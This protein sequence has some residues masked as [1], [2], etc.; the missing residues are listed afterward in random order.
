M[1]IIIILFTF[2]PLMVFGSNKNCY[3][4]KDTLMNEATTSCD[5]TK[6]SNNS[7]MYWQYNCDRIWLTL[8]NRN[9]KKFVINE[10]PVHLYGYTYRLGFHLI[11]EFEN[12]L[13]FRTG[14]PANGSCIY[15]LIDKTNGKQIKEFCQLIC[16]DTD[17]SYNNPHKY[18]FDF[19]VFFSGYSNNIIV[20]FI[21]S[22]K[23]YKVPFYEKFTSIVPEY[24]FYDMKLS[25]QN[26]L[27]LY[28]E[29]ETGNK[30]V[31][32]IN[33]NDKKYKH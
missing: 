17:I 14:C 31:F 18:K 1:K 28:Y 25:N 22:K 19:V 16:I 10:V 24:K 27:F 30:K 4:D 20:Y 33:L 26:I 23:Y 2:L 15:K 6:F 29:T 3:C 32:K 13:L 11:K 21:N 9:N 5:T 8:E 7:I 12:S